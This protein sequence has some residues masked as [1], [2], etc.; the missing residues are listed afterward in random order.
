MG[1]SSR[2]KRDSSGIDWKEYRRLVKARRKTL[3]RQ[4]RWSKDENVIRFLMFSYHMSLSKTWGGFID[5]I[6]GKVEGKKP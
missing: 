6:T 3:S 1:S 4:E 2:G 5:L